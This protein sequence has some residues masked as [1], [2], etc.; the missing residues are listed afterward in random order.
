MVTSRGNSFYPNLA[1]NFSQN[2]G[3]ITGNGPYT[4]SSGGTT[5]VTEVL[6][7]TVD[8][9]GNVTLNFTVKEG[10]Y[11]R[12]TFKF[13]GKAGSSPPSVRNMISGD[14]QPDAGSGFEP[15]TSGCG[16]QADLEGGGTETGFFTM[17]NQ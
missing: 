9:S 4:Y 16:Y 10:T 11:L 15:C 12:A 5:L 17:S 3:V 14:P 8:D 2:G 6:N 7:G 13:T 1:V